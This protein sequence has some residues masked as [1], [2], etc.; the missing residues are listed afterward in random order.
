MSAV[1]APPLAGTPTV[2]PAPSAR[3]LV[4]V[5]VGCTAALGLGLLLLSLV[6][7]ATLASRLM[8]AA[9]EAPRLGTFSQELSAYLDERLRF[10][11]GLLLVLAVGL[12]ATRTNLGDVMA[13]CARDAVAMRLPALDRRMVL[14]VGAP[15]LLAVIVRG[16]FIGQPMRYD[17]A[18]T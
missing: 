16:A 13:T 14:L 2:Q 7:S 17:E 15:V 8:G 11:A 4:L 5:I 3:R 18:L 9:G 12:T 10:A 6:P 1:T